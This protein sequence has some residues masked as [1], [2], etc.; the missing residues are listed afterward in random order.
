VDGLFAPVNG[1]AEIKLAVFLQD[2]SHVSGPHGEVGMVPVAQHPQALEFGALDIDELFGIGAAALANLHL[3]QAA[4]FGLE[5]LA[6]LVLDGQAVAIPA[7]HVGA[8]KARHLAGLDDD[9]LE[10][11]VQGMPQVNVAVGIG[12]TV[13]QDKLGAPLTLRPDPAIQVEVG[14]AFQK[15]R[16][17]P[18]QIGF[19]GK[20]GVGQVK[21]LFIIH[22]AASGAQFYYVITS[23]P[24]KESIRH[25]RPRPEPGSVHRPAPGK[26]NGRRPGRLDRS[27]TFG[28]R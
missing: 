14:P 9:I 8:I 6:H 25:G 3:G 28:I 16:L 23:P 27:P 20:I 19:H 1:A 2:F 21:G 22:A 12:G 26:S 17:P 24:G 18:G 7:R 5:L 10:N 13:M 11:F 15:Q 4:A